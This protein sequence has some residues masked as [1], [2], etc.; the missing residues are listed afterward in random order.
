M[1]KGLYVLLILAVLSMFLYETGSALG[2][3]DEYYFGMTLYDI[4]DLAPDDGT[5]IVGDGQTWV[6][7]S[8][9][10]AR[11]SLGLGTG[12]SPIFAG[13]GFTGVA[14]GVSPVASNQLAIKEYVDTA[15]SGLHFNL[16]LDNLDSTIN[17]PETTNDYYSLQITETGAGTSTLTAY[18]SLGQGDNQEVVSYISDASLPFAELQAG[19]IQAHFHARKDNTGQRDT[20]LFGKLYHRA[21][22]GTEILIATTEDSAGLTNSWTAYNLHGNITSV[23][24]FSATDRL[25]LKIRADVQSTGG[26]NAAIE[27]R[28]EGSEASFVSALVDTD[29]LSNIFL[30]QD[31]TKPLTDNWAVGGF[32]LSGV[33]TLSSGKHTITNDGSAVLGLL[34]QNDDDNC[35]MTL[36][37]TAAGNVGAMMIGVGTGGSNFY[38][39]SDNGGNPF[40][41]NSVAQANMLTG[42]AAGATML[43]SL[44]TNGNLEVIGSL[45]SGSLTA[46]RV[47]FIG[48]NGLITDGSAFTFQS[49][50]GSTLNVVN[51]HTTDRVRASGGVSIGNDV[52][53]NLIDDSSNGSASTTLYIGDE[54]IDT[55]P[56]SDEKYK[57]N[58]ID[59]DVGLAEL[60]QLRVRDFNY[61]QSMGKGNATRTGFVAQEVQS[62]YPAAVKTG[63]R[64]IKEKV[65]IEDPNNFD[66]IIEPEITEDFLFVNV[67]EFIPILIKVAQIQQA[68]IEDLTNRVKI[69]EKR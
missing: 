48:A 56:V 52:F 18:A 28:Q 20:V 41:W 62:V 21:S 38:T 3:G 40:N 15:V 29:T 14:V 6:A 35:R 67:R 49:G 31:G 36:T 64:M 66:I 27:I 53:A 37:K 12:D 59:S 57:E 61:I 23:V 9:N 46:G 11:T 54:T 68:R 58:I 51:L 34:I 13:G 45:T 17:D 2:W 63:V 30:R 60:M 65:T 50:G 69:L 7:E 5:F 42:S 24:T 47:P 25:L 39:E 33:G 55:T 26:G 44:A 19:L 16:F 22:G 43:M 10:T 8:G 32:N 4:G 1:K